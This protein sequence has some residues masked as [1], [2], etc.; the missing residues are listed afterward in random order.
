MDNA[1]ELQQYHS[2]IGIHFVV[3]ITV[4][5]APLL[6]RKLYRIG[7]R[8]VQHYLIG[9]VHSAVQID[10]AVQAGRCNIAAL[11]VLWFHLRRKLSQ[12]FRQNSL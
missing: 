3:G 12:W 5:I 7:S 10:I 4:C 6:F 2:I 1:M 8:L 9:N 11:V